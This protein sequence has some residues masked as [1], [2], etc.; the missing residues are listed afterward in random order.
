M[1]PEHCRPVV[2]HTC[3]NCRHYP[4][5]IMA[6][7]KGTQCEHTKSLNKH[8]LN[9]QGYWRDAC[10]EYELIEA[11]QHRRCMD[12]RHL[13]EKP[14]PGQTASCKQS[15]E[16]YYAWDTDGTCDGLV[17]CAAF[18]PNCDAFE[19]YE[20][21]LPEGQCCGKCRWDGWGYG[22]SPSAGCGYVSRYDGG[23]CADFESLQPAG[24]GPDNSC[25]DCQLSVD[26]ICKAEGRHRPGYD[27]TDCE[28]YEPRRARRR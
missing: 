10:N 21:T 2:H 22:T 11:V 25:E 15:D 4:D 7:I 14:P 20:P 5:E 1:I 3:G 13:P 17:T 12:C 19:P 8:M 28:H 16:Q 6:V 23:D 27:A 18:E 9:A 26:G 24:K